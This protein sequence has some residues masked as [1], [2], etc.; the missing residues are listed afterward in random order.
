MTTPV[1]ANFALY[2]DRYTQ[3]PSLIPKAALWVDN[4]ALAA[5]TVANYTVPASGRVLL[6]SY[7]DPVVYVNFT[8]A[9]AVPSTNTTNG[10]GSDICP[11][12]ACVSAGDVVSFICA[13]AAKVAIRVYGG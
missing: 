2:R 9:A 4:M 10:T 5:N 13:N 3:S 12:G 8:G 11:S 7:S 6:L 1:V